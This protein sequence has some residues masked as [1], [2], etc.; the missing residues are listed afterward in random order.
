MALETQAPKSRGSVIA[1]LGN[2]EVM[3]LIGQLGYVTPEIYRSFATGNS[4]KRRQQAY[5]DYLKF[6]AA[7][8]GHGHSVVP[9]GDEA[10]R[11]KWMDEHPLGF[12][13][14]RDAFGSAGKCAGGFAPTMRSCRLAMASSYTAA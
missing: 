5:L 14:H 7:H 11:A 13:E 6:L 3:N 12:V 8:A 1:L 9:P 4:E 2:H 10:E